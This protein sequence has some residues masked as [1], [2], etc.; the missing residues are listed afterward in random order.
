MTDRERMRGTGVLLS[1]RYKKGSGPDWKGEIKLERDYRAGDTVKLAAWAKETS[2]GALISL[3]E[4][5]LQPENAADTNQP[6]RANRNPFPSRRV[7]SDDDI[8]F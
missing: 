1:N 4:D 3:K 2:V 8:P 6:P 7:D 5:N